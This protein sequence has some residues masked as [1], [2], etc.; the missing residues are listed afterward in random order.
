M[1]F[2]KRGRPP[3]DRLA[4]QREIYLAVAPLIM[5]QGARRLSMRQ[6]ARAAHL[7]IGG[8]YHYFPTKRDLVLHGLCAAAIVRCCDEFHAAFGH[9]SEQSPQRYLE[10][11]IGLVITHLSFCRPA[12]YAALELG[13]ESFWDV[14]DTLLTNTALDFET[15][16]RRAAP[17]ASAE[18][19]QQCGQAIRRTI[20]A[21]I[22]DRRVSPDELRGELRILVDGYLGRA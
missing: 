19:L 21:A 4:R 1:M 17:E 9:L 22:L 3:E 16:L 13:S 7:S 11:G 6:A 10:E 18:E 8:L 20:C 5:Q 15:H 2:G 12:V 14:V